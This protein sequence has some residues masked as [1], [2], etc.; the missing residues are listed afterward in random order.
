M[1]RGGLAIISGEMTPPSSSRGVGGADRVRRN[2]CRPRRAR[3]WKQRTALA[4]LRGVQQQRR[5]TGAGRGRSRSSSMGSMLGPRSRLRRGE[6]FI[7]CT[8]RAG[9]SVGKISAPRPITARR[10]N[11]L[12]G[13]PNAANASKASRADSHGQALPSATLWWTPP[14]RG[15]ERQVWPEIK[16]C[17]ESAEPW[18]YAAKISSQ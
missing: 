3:Q 10:E 15:G 16:E 5:S 8:V 2:C 12:S 18:L 4:R 14:P 6:R 13:A 1:R 11:G 7:L 9:H 17:R